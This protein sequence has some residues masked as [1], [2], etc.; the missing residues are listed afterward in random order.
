MRCGADKFTS[1]GGAG[2]SMFDDYSLEYRL[3][4]KLDARRGLADAIFKVENDWPQSQSESGSLP[5]ST[6]PPNQIILKR[7]GQDL[8]VRPPSSSTESTR[9]GGGSAAVPPAGMHVVSGSSHTLP[10]RPGSDGS[11]GAGAVPPP[12][13]GYG[14]SGGASAPMPPPPRAAEAMRPPPPPSAPP[15]G[16]QQPPPAWGKPSQ[17]RDAAAKLGK[18]WYSPRGTMHARG[19]DGRVYSEE[20]LQKMTV[21]EKLNEIF[22]LR[23]KSPR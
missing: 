20:A 8:P 22:P 19:A 2:S 12:G 23:H 11:S 16:E 17:P 14:Y 18:V 5:R 21:E 4:A 13:V 9:S 1:F 3:D 7:I 15:P 6:G 10:P